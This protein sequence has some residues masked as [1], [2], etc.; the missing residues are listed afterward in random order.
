MDRYP[1]V[2]TIKELLLAEG[3]SGALITGSGPTVFGIFS[4]ERDA[5]GARTR[6]MEKGMGKW[7]VIPTQSA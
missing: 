4:H 7:I 2:G 3:A 1:E 6:L 5:Q